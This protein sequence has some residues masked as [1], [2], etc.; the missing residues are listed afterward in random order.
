M[1][2]TPLLIYDREGLTGAMYNN[3]RHGISRL[4][5]I[6]AIIIIIAVAALSS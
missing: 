6:A 5:A 4:L 2:L 3:P 1:F